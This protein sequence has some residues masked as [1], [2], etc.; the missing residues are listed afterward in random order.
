MNISSP[1]SDEPRSFTTGE[2][3]AS[4]VTAPRVLEAGTSTVNAV[5]SADAESGI[6]SELLSM[7]DDKRPHTTALPSELD[8][9]VISRSTKRRDT[10]IS[11]TMVGIHILIKRP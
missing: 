3:Q 10:S 9:D 7:R 4:L 5:G 1:Y 11:R 8:N 2:W 6:T